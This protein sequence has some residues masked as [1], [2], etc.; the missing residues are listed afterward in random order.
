MM[1]RSIA[2]L[3]V[4]VLLAG[5]QV[6]PGDLPEPLPA[7]A[8]PAMRELITAERLWETSRPQSYE[9]TVDVRCFCGGLTT[10]PPRYSVTGTTATA[11][12][13]LAPWDGKTYSR[14]NTVE[15]L[16]LVVRQSMKSDGHRVTV[17]YD[18]DLGY[19]Q[20]ADLDPLVTA[21][22]DEMFFRVIDFRKK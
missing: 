10:V 15:K 7:N 13:P 20:V 11:V 22:D 4:S 16:F 3:L 17:S 21:I 8:S 19:P 12:G 6:N 9:F 14:F 5:C 1:S 18:P 2:P